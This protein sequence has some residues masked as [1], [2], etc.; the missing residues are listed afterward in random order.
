M[1]QILVL[2]TL[3][4]MQYGVDPSISLAIIEVESSFKPEAK[5]K[6]GEIGLMQLKPKFFPGVS[7]DVHSN[8]EYGI[9]Y[10]SEVK[11]V[12]KGFKGTTWVICYNQGPRSA[13][14]ITAPSRQR[15]YRRVAAALCK[16]APVRGQSPLR[17]CKANEEG[18]GKK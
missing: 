17:F 18:L 5:G 13:R 10:L 12:C 15:Y 9:K 7:Q 6:H 11:R 16:R 8:L 14:G 1:I 4:S 3:L 2:S